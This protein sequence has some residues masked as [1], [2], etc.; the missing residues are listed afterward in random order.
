[1]KLS[2]KLPL[3]AILAACILGLVVPSSAQPPNTDDKQK[4]GDRADAINDLVLAANLAAFGR[5][6]T[7]DLTG[8]KKTIVKSPEA[9]VAAG[10]ILMRIHKLTEGK[11]ETPDLKPTDKDGKPITGDVVKAVDYKTQA[12]ALFD[13]ARALAGKDKAKAIEALIKEAQTQEVRGAVGSPR[14]ISR[15]IAPGANHSWKIPFVA[16]APAAISITSTGQSRLQMEIVNDGG[17]Q[18]LNV[19]GTN[20]NY[21][22]TTA[23][24]KDGHPRTITVNV[25]NTG[26]NPTSYTINTN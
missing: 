26:N 17:G 25:T 16:G 18:L 10:G 24:T 22:W 11:I 8:L 15:N 21:S 23:A 4:A 6:E 1:M 9:L 2:R 13:E 20:S 5:G 7:G 12:E 19:R 3:G 14:I